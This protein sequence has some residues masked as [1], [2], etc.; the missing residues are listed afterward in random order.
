MSQS[1]STSAGGAGTQI[2]QAQ[3]RKNALVARFESG[4]GDLIAKSPNP[5]FANKVFAASVVDVL[6]DPKKAACKSSSIMKAIGI[7]VAYE[8]MPTGL[9]QISFI[10]F[11]DEL[12]A[13]IGY[14]GL[15]ALINRDRKDIVIFA[16]TIY[17]NDEYRME[18]G[19]HRR[20]IHNPRLD[21]ERGTPVAYYATG[22]IGA[23]V[24]PVIVYMTHAEMQAHRQK[25]APK[26][27]V[28]AKHFNRMSLKTCIKY[29]AKF[30]PLSIDMQE[31]L[32]ADD[33]PPGAE[34]AAG[35]AAEAAAQQQAPPTPAPIVV[36]PDPPPVEQPV[37]PE[38]VAPQPVAN[39]APAAEPAAQ[40]A[41]AA[42]PTGLDDFDGI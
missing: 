38:P 21:G 1:I 23:S 7:A 12:Q 18:S 32:A 16:D 27:Q 3:E 30:L 5:G 31:K 6:Q 33:A 22:H 10:P 42:E 26:S 36:E 8:L 41:P 39:T 19:S 25:H 28:W 17:S 9:N 40:P 11:K 24:Q 2:A 4:R 35:I 37:T 29:L 20:I 14:Q 34:E 15:I 13:V